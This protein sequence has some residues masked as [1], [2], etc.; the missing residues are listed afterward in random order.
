MNGITMMIV[1]VLKSQGV[2]IDAEQINAAWEQ[3][4]DALPKIAAEFEQ[5]N[6]RLAAIE[7]QLRQK[8]EVI[9]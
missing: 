1:S 3:A 7:D 8:N 6:K 4:K 9:Q 2:K 5:M